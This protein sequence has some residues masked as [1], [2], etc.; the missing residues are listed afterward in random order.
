MANLD[1]KVNDVKRKKASSRGV[2]KKLKT[3]VDAIP[4]RRSGRVTV[5]KLKSEL[6]DLRNDPKANKEVLEKKVFI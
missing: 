5:E 3:P 4:V 1:A 2:L 6:E